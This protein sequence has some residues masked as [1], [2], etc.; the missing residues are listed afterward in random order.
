[1]K[2]HILISALFLFIFGPIMGQTDAGKLVYRM[3]IEGPNDT[4]IAAD[5]PN[6]ITT[7]YFMGDL[8]RTETEGKLGK[9]VLI[10][11]LKTNIGH[12]L[13]NLGPQKLAIEIDYNKDTSATKNPYR[14]KNKCG[15]DI[16]A[17]HKVNKAIVHRYNK[18]LELLY[19]KKTNAKYA[20]AYN[21]AKG[22]P[23]KYHLIVDSYTETYTC[24]ELK[25]E[26]VS[27][28][29]F[30]IPQAYLRLTMEEF[31]EGIQSGNP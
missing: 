3:S 24:T 11:N 9:Q 4:L 7:I 31:M 6:R 29:K 5:S 19:L 30:D 8:V 21:E 27:P 2:K 22:I 10:Q 25:F 12:L 13:L 26:A 23:L 16:V 1:M 15:K 18:E 28:K 17:G 14:I 20:P